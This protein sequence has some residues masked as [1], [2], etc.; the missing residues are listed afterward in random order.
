M[1]AKRLKT[2]IFY[3][4]FKKYAKNKILY[5]NFFIFKLKMGQTLNILIAIKASKT[6]I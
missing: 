6:I 1:K 5:K 2:E 3:V 4:F